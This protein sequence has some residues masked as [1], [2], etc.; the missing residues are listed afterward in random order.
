MDIASTV[1]YWLLLSNQYCVRFAVSQT[2]YFTI[3][4]DTSLANGVKHGHVS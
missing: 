3:T 2:D 1:T 4:M